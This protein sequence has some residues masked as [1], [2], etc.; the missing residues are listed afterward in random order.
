MAGSLICPVVDSFPVAGMNPQS[1]STRTLVRLLLLLF[2][3]F[4]PPSPP[5][6]RLRAAEP[7]SSSTSPREVPFVKGHSWGWTGRRGEYAAPEAAD[8]LVRLAATGADTV[9][10]PFATTMAHAQTPE[11]TWGDANPRMVSETK[12]AGLSTWPARISF[13]SS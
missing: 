12:S 8:S 3:L 6:T 11:F 10:I 1:H 13:A 5:E 2:L 4:F 9:C 7:S